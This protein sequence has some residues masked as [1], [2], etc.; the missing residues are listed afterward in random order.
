[1][2][3]EQITTTQ[4]FLELEAA[5]GELTTEPLRSFSWHAAW[6]KSF[7]DSLQLKTYVYRADGQIVGIAPFFVDRWMG[8]NRLRFI[9]SGATCSDYVEVISTPE[10]RPEF[11][12]A[13]AED[14]KVS[15][16]VSMLE[17]EGLCGADQKRRL[18]DNLASFWQ[19]ERDMEPTWVIQLP[20]TF[21]EFVKSAK[22]SLRRKINKAKKHLD[23]GE[24]TVG[25]TSDGL[26]TEFAFETLVDL[27]QKRFVS[28]GEPGVFADPKFTS[29]LRSATT[30]L[31][32][33]DKAEI[34]VGFADDK[35]FVVHLYLLGEAG[36]Q[37]YQSGACVES[38]KLE[39]GHLMITH[40]VRKAI[41]AGFQELD[42]LRGSEPY[43]MYWGAEPQE[44][45]TVRCVS[46]R[47]APTIVNRA[48][49]GLQALKRNLE[50]LMSSR[51]AAVR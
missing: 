27:H 24:V 40:V 50:S 35:P 20:S 43:K 26:E 44:L 9:G 47:F 28:K 25:S 49:L 16:S 1:M 18:P 45:L 42:F 19:Y 7:G 38:M 10:F 4:E 8:Q 29:F 2:S 48:Y 6:W 5:W 15:K 17:L 14:I 22:K 39:P 12:E 23:S 3:I 37:L 34:F 51:A 33:Q 13:I 31:I 41:Q 36:P 46:P 30:E 11:I 32:E 21:E